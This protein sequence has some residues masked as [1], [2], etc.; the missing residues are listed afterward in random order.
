MP[1]SRR[2]PP[3]VRARRLGAE[4]RRLREAAGFTLEQAA[5]AI[6]CHPSMLSRI[7]TGHRNIR[8]L[9]LRALLDKYGVTDEER[10]EAL[11]TLS[12]ESKRRD[13]WHSYSDVLARPYQDLISLEVRA[14]SLR[15]Y[16][17][18]VI[19]GLFQTAGYAYAVIQAVRVGDAPEAI[20]RRVDARMA[21]QEI[22]RREPPP[23]VWLVLDE[24]ALRRAPTA[25]PGV[26]RDQLEH[27]LEVADL[28]HVTL[29]VLPF[30]AGLHAGVDGAF[31]FLAF[32][33]VEGPSIVYLESLTGGLYIEKE[34]DVDR[35]ARVF[36][37]LRASALPEAASR[38][39][40]VECRKEY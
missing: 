8:P 9:E 21:R 13:W 40:I 19:P 4:L 27:L 17:T 33:E 39:M 15:I 31:T 23:E 30:S 35:Y 5:E 36:D 3:T 34:P 2:R 20:Q 11:L 32:P 6:E 28:P 26:M 24:A 1:K 22:L 18:Q 16:H 14:S 12:R 37:H 7:E 10:R 25:D 38:R 29:Q